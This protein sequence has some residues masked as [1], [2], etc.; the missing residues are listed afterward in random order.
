MIKNKFGH[1]MIPLVFGV[2]LSACTPQEET[3]VA[4]LEVLPI[5]ET[6]PEPTPTPEPEFEEY[7]IQLMSLGDNLIHMGVVNTGK[8]EDGSRNYDCLFETMKPYLAEA[9]IKVINQETI[10]GG[11]HLGF[12]GYPH[13]NSPTEIGD[14]IANAGFNVVLQASNHSADQG[15]EGI[16]HCAEYWDTHPEVTM[17]GIYGK[18]EEQETVKYL[19][20]DG[21]RFALLN[22]TYGPNY[23]TLIPGLAEH[24]DI[25]CDY[26]RNTGL[27]DYTSLNPKV[28]ED[29]AEAELTADFVI[30]FPH[31]GTEYTTEPSS[32]QRKFAEMM[33]EA[34]ADVIIGTHPHVVQPVEWITTSN[35]NS[36]LCY[37]SLGNYVST[38]KDTIS[39]LEAMAWV[40]F[41]VTEDGIYLNGE[42]SG[43]LPLVCHYNSGP[44]RIEAVYPLEE[45]TE[46]MAARHGITP[47][48]G[49]ILKV[50]ELEQKCNEILG[51]FVLSK[52]DI[53]Q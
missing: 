7:D 34:G 36:A 25:L 33:T 22:Y 17:L 53:V 30:V 18:E 4:K 24:M 38:Q 32:Y 13:F 37:Y 26:N 8:Q 11:N 10:F 27:M 47:Y 1:L 49:K 41:H 28:L 5:E 14:A 19:E 39:M 51:E 3:E 44:L 6:I 20:I 9:E 2:I 16:Y 21:F 42:K 50:S 46:D 35:G 12:S 52:E 31:W 23:E 29:I 43:A 40:S 48:G 45:Y 15:M